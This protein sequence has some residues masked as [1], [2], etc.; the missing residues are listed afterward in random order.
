MK[1]G[2]VST[3]LQT[4]PGRGLALLPEQFKAFLTFAQILLEEALHWFTTPVEVL[5][6]RK[7]GCRWASPLLVGQLFVMACCGALLGWS[8]VDPVFGVLTLAPFAVSIYRLREARKWEREGHP[9]RHSYY[10]GE[11]HPRLWTAIGVGL[12]RLGLRPERWLT[13]NR[14]DRFAQPALCL[15]A[16]LVVLPVSRLL[17]G[18]LIVASVAL[19]VKG[20]LIHNRVVN[21]IRDQKDAL[22]TGQWMSE[23]TAATSSTPAEVVFGVRVVLPAPKATAPDPMPV[24]LPSNPRVSLRCPGCQ[25]RLLAS[26]NGQ[27]QTRP[28]PKC[29]TEVEVPAAV[30]AV[31]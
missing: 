25:S 15:V 24:P 12:I 19:F 8:L 9:W 4:E 11:P 22:V 31:C 26:V 21:L 5:A 23:T 2:D 6:R 29:A 20:H 3:D 7:F 10:R 16:G 13:T 14:I 30:E 27:P 17:G 18:Y 1:L 28:C